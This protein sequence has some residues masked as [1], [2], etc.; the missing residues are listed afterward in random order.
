MTGVLADTHALLWLLYDDARLSTRARAA[1]VHGHRD[2][3]L[4][5]SAISL[6]EIVYLIDKQR[7]SPEV[8]P[9]MVAAVEHADLPIT[10]LPVDETVAAAVARVPLTD[11]P[12]MPDRIIA[13]TALVAELPLVTRDA[14]LRA[15]GLETIW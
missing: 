7:L 15:A 12:D 11:V 4:H 5:V 10:V 8:W 14:R 13:A 6:V 1:L 9:R 2:V 3:A